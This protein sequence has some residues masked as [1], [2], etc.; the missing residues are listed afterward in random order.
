MSQAKVARNTWDQFK[1]EIGMP[2]ILFVGQEVV[3]HS[4]VDNRIDILAFNPNEGLPIVIELK[5]GK[6]KLQLL[7]SI[8]YASMIS[9]WSGEDFIKIAEENK[10]PDLEDLK[11]SLTDFDNEL[12]RIV[13]LAEKYDPEVII[14]SDWLY[15]VYNL[16]IVACSL[17]VF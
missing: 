15:R 6:N 2:D 10:S 4:S 11:S 8:S 3:P 16:D 17:N 9:S 5:R 12:V 7:Q 14:S 13:L 1:N